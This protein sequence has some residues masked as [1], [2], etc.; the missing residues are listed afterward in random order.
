MSSESESTTSRPLQLDHTA[1]A[2]L[3]V[4]L[5]S[6]SPYLS[7]PP[8]ICAIHPALAYVGPVGSHMRD[9]QVLSVPKT[10]T[11]WLDERLRLEVVSALERMV[12]AGRGVERV[13]VV[14][15]PTARAKREEL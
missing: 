13:E 9:A 4:Y 7:D 8:S 2:Y 3:I 11:G 12:G 10:A 14:A 15:E 5:A 1:H 6:S